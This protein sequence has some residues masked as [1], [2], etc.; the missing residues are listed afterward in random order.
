MAEEESGGLFRKSAQDRISS[1]EQLDKYIKVANP[2][3]WVTLA[4]VIVFLVA[5]TIWSFSGRIPTTVSI[6]GIARDGA[7]CCYLSP[8]KV[9][10][11]KVGDSAVVLGQSTGEVTGISATPIS[12]NEASKNIES[13]Y[14]VSELNLSE[15][16]YVV[17][18]STADVPAE[19]TLV[20][21]KITTEEVAPMSFLFN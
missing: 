20:P 3:V 21:V 17:T 8:D 7:I 18:I 11:L 14:T 12:A 19:G 6:N 16:N 2:S 9:G 13:D 10:E 15:W 4:A 1:P 5:I